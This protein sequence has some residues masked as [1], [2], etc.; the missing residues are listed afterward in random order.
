M[1]LK[2]VEDRIES[3]T[4]LMLRHTWLVTIGGG[5]ALVGLGAA[6]FYFA[7]QPT[8]LR[9]AVGPPNS[10]DLRAIQS[11]AQHFARERAAI[12]LRLIVKDGP[13]QSSAALDA[14]EADVAVVRRDRA[15]PQT[16]QAV[17]IL[18]RNVVVLV[19]P[20]PAPPALATPKA[21]RAKKNSAKEEEVKKLE[22]IEELAGKRIAVIGRTEA[23]VNLLNVILKQ[24][25]I[26]PDKVEV[27]QLGTTDV[28]PAIR[29]S[30]VDAIMAVGPLSSRITADVIAAASREREA[31]SFLAID[32]SEAI[33]QRYP[34]Y[35]STEIPAGAFGGAPPRPAEAVETIGVSHYIVAH[36]SLG[37]SAVGEFARLLFVARQALS[38]DVPAVSKIEPPETDKD[39]AVAVH[40]GAAAYIDG[41]Q[42]SFFDRYDNWIYYGLMLLSFVGS[43]MVWLMN[44]S[45]AGDR[46]QKLHAL[47]Q[48]MDLI[49]AA[50]NAP[51]V[52]ALEQL[53]AKAD[54]ILQR[55]IQ[56]VENN[57]LDQAALQALAL[58]LEQ[59]R[60]AIADRRTVLGGPAQSSAMV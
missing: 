45:K 31:P 30:K 44:Y 36:R 58:A 23:N 60:R 48:L 11:V 12:R 54:D 15:M 46:V 59:T 22:K 3:R 13:V 26:A 5:L 32:T 28:G 47:D 20:P 2:T 52:D 14:G 53:Q 24:Y 7:S 9:I 25:E 29:D 33:A 4:R 27:I 17:A 21:K 43:A 16:G 41:E 42:K 19:A 10:D 57:R 8:T 18:R 55:T 34:V 35:E 1:N 40:P 51:D 39:A 37:E 49:R 6:A 56:Q 38:T 50:R